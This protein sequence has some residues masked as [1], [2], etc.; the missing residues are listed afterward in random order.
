MALGLAPRNR[1][2][3][4]AMYVGCAECAG[5]SLPGYYFL[6]QNGGSPHLGPRWYLSRKH[7]QKPKHPNAR[8]PGNPRDPE[9]ENIRIE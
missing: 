9:K 7:T 8:G 4:R 2:A 3:H 5:F 1:V 6:A